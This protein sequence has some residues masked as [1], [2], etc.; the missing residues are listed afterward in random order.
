MTTHILA[1]IGAI[2]LIVRTA[3]LIPGALADLLD[4]CHRLVAAAHNL[5]EALAYHPAP[6]A[7]RTPPSDPDADAEPRG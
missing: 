4:A 1:A 6:A 3:I 2:V 7:S 5:R